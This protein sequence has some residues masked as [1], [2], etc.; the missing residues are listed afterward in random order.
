M[1]Q[2]KKNSLIETITQNTVGLIIS[3]IVQSILYPILGIP[4]SF[5]QNIIITI[6][7]LIVS[8]VRG[9]VIRRIFDKIN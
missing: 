2:S 4:V 7:F 8:L 1:K 6:V 9:Y 5:K 3:L